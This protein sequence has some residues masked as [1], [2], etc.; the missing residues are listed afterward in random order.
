MIRLRS[1]KVLR[2]ARERNWYEERHNKVAEIYQC[3]RAPSDRLS[4]ARV[5]KDLLN[6]VWRL[7]RFGL[8]SSTRLEATIKAF[9]S[10]HPRP[11]DSQE[12][13]I[14]VMDQLE[15]MT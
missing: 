10:A 2:R 3:V 6:D 1:E 5:R 12:F 14:E 8:V 13:V 11:R 9:Q 15:L 4:T 7:G